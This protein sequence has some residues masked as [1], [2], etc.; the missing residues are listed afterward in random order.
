MFL[1]IAELRS[2]LPDILGDEEYLSLLIKTATDLIKQYTGR[3]IEYG[4]YE[5]VVNFTN[6]KIWITESPIDEVI[7]LEVDG[8]IITDYEKFADFILITQFDKGQAK[9]RYKGGYKEIPYP[10]KYAC[11]LICK[12]L[13]QRLKQGIISRESIGVISVDFLN[14]DEIKRSISHYLARYIVFRL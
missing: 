12:F 2:F 3:Q 1:T 13:H 11:A 5:E 7:S 10:I 4:E 14:E 9:I 6:G 8:I